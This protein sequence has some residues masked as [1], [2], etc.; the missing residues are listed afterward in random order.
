MAEERR[1]R[2]CGRMF[3]PDRLVGVRQKVCSAACGKLRK[4]ENN[5]A[6]RGK[7]QDYWRGRYE[8]VKAWRA[9]HPDYQKTGGSSGGVT[10]THVRYKPRCLPKPLMPL[11]NRR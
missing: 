1:C 5:K 8:V 6:F 3:V 11:R 7:N 9:E 10:E 4:R 2:Y